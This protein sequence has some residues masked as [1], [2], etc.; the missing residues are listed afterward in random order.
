MMREAGCT[1]TWRIGLLA[2]IAALVCAAFPAMAAADT[3]TIGYAGA[4]QA[5]TVPLGVNS[6][7][8][9]LYGAAGTDNGNNGFVGGKGGRATA[10]LNVTP[11]QLVRIYVGGAGGFLAGGWNGGGHGFA[12]GGGGTDLRIGGTGLADRVLVAGGGGGVGNYGG[13]SQGGNGGGLVGTS[14]NSP[15]AGAPGTQTAGGAGTWP[16]SLGQGGGGGGGGS[17]AARGGGGGGYYGGSTNDQEGGGGSGYGPAG[18]VFETG[19]REG[20]GQAILTYTPVRHALNVNVVGPGQGRVSS[21]PAGIDCGFNGGIDCSENFA[22][23]TQVTLTATPEPGRVFTGWSGACSGSSPTCNVSMTEARTIEARFAQARTLSVTKSG[24]GGGSLGSTP[25]GISCDLGC[26]EDTADFELGSSITL[27]AVPATGSNFSFWSGGGC[28][29]TSSTCTVT[30]SQARNVMATFTLIEHPLTVVKKGN[31]AGNVTSEPSG[32]ICGAT[33][34]AD[35]L[36]GTSVTLT[37]SPGGDSEFGGWSGDGCSDASTTCIVNMDQART[38]EASFVLQKRTLTVSRTG[39]GSGLVSSGPAGI[40]CGSDCEAAFDLGSAV[41]LVP[42]P[43]PGSD[44]AGWSGACAGSGAACI[45]TIDQARSVEAEFSLEKRTLFVTKSGT[46][47]VDSSPAGISCGSDCVGEYDFGGSVTLTVTPAAGSTFKGWE[48]A[49]SGAAATCTV[50]M[51]EARSVSAAFTSIPPGTTITRAPRKTKRTK[52]K[53]T[54]VKFAFRSDQAGSTFECKLDRR[55]F[56]TCGS[57][58]RL[59]VKRGKHTFQVRAI[60]AAGVA[61]P[62]PAKYRFRV[63]KKR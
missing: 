55:P 34:N 28:S 1:S 43:A 40:D 9:D 48:G 52:E 33:C 29:G 41:T 39:N 17:L 8:F 12:G 30:M 37:A 36:H 3:E 20:N 14:G 62:A 6:V 59:K 27:T 35:Y 11:G 54:K 21:A 7:E 32:I 18:T 13:A 53:W 63:L 5:W 16:G 50:T 56:T 61:D 2:V 49:C 47:T 19:V 57:P 58:V 10:T 26:S 42:D 23:G 22:E 38:L 44:F 46:G 45:V 15:T 25:A 31:G 51:N 60:N 4:P 24:T